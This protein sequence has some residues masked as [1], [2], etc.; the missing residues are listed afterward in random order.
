[1]YINLSS[2][3]KKAIAKAMRLITTCD[4]KVNEGERQY[5]TNGIIP[6]IGLSIAEFE[7]AKNF[8]TELMRTVLKKMTKVN[9]IE[10]LTMMLK[11]ILIDG[12]ISND[13]MQMFNSIC[14]I[15]ELDNDIKVSDIDDDKLSTWYLTLLYSRN[16]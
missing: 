6:Q 4:N 11:M 16:F 2:F 7:E 13:E 14:L 8:D 3:E 9:R 1:M 15:G 10:L 5:L 12:D